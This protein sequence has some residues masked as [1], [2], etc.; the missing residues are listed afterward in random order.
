MVAI[1]LKILNSVGGFPIHLCGE[2]SIYLGCYQKSKN[3]MEPSGPAS[4]MV[5]LME[6]STSLICWKNSS[7]CDICWTTKVH[8]S[9]PHPRR[10]QCSV[11]SSVLK[12]LHVDICHK[13]AHC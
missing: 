3:G 11:D 8:I 12:S 4:S 6:V 5:N 7:L 9:S 1:P 10:V 2:G 13:W